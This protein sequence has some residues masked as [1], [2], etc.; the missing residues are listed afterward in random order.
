MKVYRDFKE[1]NKDHFLEGCVLSI[2]NFDGLHLGHQ[3]L[4]Q[5]ALKESKKHG[6]P[7][8]VYTFHPHPYAFLNPDK[9]F[10]RIF[11]VSDLEERLHGLGTQHLVIQNFDESFSQLT[12]QEFLE[13][14]ILPLLKP[15]AI[16]VGKNFNFGKGRSGNI[17]YLEKV[18]KKFDFQLQVVDEVQSEG[19]IISS[20]LIRKNIQ[21]GNMKKV[22]KLLDRSFS[23]SGKVQRGHGRGKQLG[24]PTAN[25]YGDGIIL[26]LKGVYFC[27]TYLKNKKYPTITNVGLR[28]T[29]QHSGQQVLIEAHILEKLEDFYNEEITVE[30]HE[31]LRKEQRFENKEYL[32]KQIKEDMKEAGKFFNL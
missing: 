12:A 32:V 27:T 15:K 5:E 19:E 31:F 10:Y 1:I 2:G 18:S 6:V 23:I 17:D 20:T 26:P 4:L 21:K 25:I 22:A 30:F 13:E 16:V 29:F 7:L 3:K 14:K 11:Y 9:D 24:F 8:V 28:P